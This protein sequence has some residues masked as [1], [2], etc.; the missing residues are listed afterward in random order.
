MIG[1]HMFTAMVKPPRADTPPDDDQVPSIE[2]TSSTFANNVDDE[3][4]V[5]QLL[6]EKPT[7][8]VADKAHM[9]KGTKTE[10]STTA[11]SQAVR[12]LRPLRALLRQAR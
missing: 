2:R 10:G 7:I 9:F 12:R 8:V 5:A 4:D 1:Y 11:V 6:L 3:L